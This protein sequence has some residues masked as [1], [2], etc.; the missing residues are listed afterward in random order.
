MGGRRPALGG[1]ERNHQH[2]RPEAEHHL[3]FAEEVQQFRREARNQRPIKRT[4]AFLVLMLESVREC[5]E[6]RGSKRVDD[7]QEKDG[8]RHQVERFGLDAGGE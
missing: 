7:G 3:Y 2:D 4:R 1:H 8:E 6:A 5:G